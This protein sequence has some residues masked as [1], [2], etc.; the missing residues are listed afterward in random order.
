MIEPGLLIGGGSGHA[1]VDD[2]QVLVR[3][4]GGHSLK[5]LV[6]VFGSLH[7]REGVG[8]GRGGG[9]AV[10]GRHD[11][12]VPV[13]ELGGRLAVL[14]ER[15]ERANRPNP[16][17]VHGDVARRYRPAAVQQ[18]GIDVLAGWR[19]VA[20]PHGVVV[21]VPGGLPAVRYGG[22]AVGADERARS[23]ARSHTAGVRPLEVDTELCDLAGI[24]AGICRLLAVGVEGELGSDRAQRVPGPVLAVPLIADLLRQVGK[25]LLREDVLV[26][27]DEARVDKVWEPDLAIATLFQEVK[28]RRRIFRRV[29][30]RCLDLRGKVKEDSTEAVSTADPN[31]ADDVRRVAGRDLGLEDV[32]C[33]GVRDDLEVDVDLVLGCVVRLDERLLSFDLVGLESLAEAYEPADDGHSLWNCNARNRGPA[34]GR[35]SGDRRG[36]RATASAKDERRNGGQCDEAQSSSSHWAPFSNPW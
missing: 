26:V 29:V 3:H 34:R 10:I 28:D 31:R 2:L 16:G 13:G 5:G 20:F 32:V 17:Y 18:G 24:E 11:S 35:R 30:A 15:A 14:T 1:A 9:R 21:P 7:D 12:D 6:R 33:A 19:I 25:V 23:P 4:D 36:D 8:I 22:L 27:E